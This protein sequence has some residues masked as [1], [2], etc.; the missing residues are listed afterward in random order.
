[1]KSSTDLSNY[2]ILV[3]GNIL[4]DSLITITPNDPAIIELVIPQSVKDNNVKLTLTEID[5]YNLDRIN[6]FRPDNTTFILD[7]K[8][9]TSMSIVELIFWIVI[10]LIVLFI[11]LWFAFIRNQKYPK[12][13]RGIINI[14]SP[15]F[16]SIRV[17]GARM[18]VLSPRSQVQ[19]WFD[20][21]WRG[22]VIYH[23]NA[24]W[25]CEV[26]IT[27]AGKNMR[28]R[29]PSGQLISD[30]SPLLTRGEAYKII[31]TSDSTS[32]IDININ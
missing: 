25:P 6:G 18:V 16:A 17:K 8:Y 20:K 23:I 5:S 24:A 2:T 22:R 12:F 4:R 30:P 26:E 28:F 7:G 1:L 13:S 11:V 14:Q 9:T 21:L 19:G 3:N 27:P 32:K 31:N 15:Y 10:G 29:C